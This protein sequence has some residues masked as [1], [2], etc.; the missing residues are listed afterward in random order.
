V[1]IEPVIEPPPRDGTD[2]DE[3]AVLQQLADR[4]TTLLRSHAEYWAASFPI[5]WDEP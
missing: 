5:A 4:W 1:R 2:E 3:A